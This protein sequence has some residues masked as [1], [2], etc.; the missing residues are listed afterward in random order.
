LVPFDVEPGMV[1][2]N[3]S[4]YVTYALPVTKA[5]A[6]APTIQVACPLTSEVPFIVDLGGTLEVDVGTWGSLA[7][8][9]TLSLNARGDQSGSS[10]SLPLTVLG[11]SSARLT[12]QITM[13]ARASPH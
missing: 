9:P 11:Q 1:F 8:A 2:T 4:L 12:V 6:I 3:P 10:L 7:L 5:V 13:W